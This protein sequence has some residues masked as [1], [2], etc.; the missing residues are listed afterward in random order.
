M[1]TS[2]PEFS[3][4]IEPFRKILEEA[5]VISGKRTK[6]SIKRIVLRRLSWNC[7]HDK[8]FREFHADPQNSV[9]IAYQ[10][11]E[12]E[13]CIYTDAS[14]EFWAA[15]V[16]Q[17]E[18]DQLDLKVDR[19]LHQPLAFLGGKLIG[20]QVNWT[21]FEKEA[22]AIYEVFEKLD[23]MLVVE[24]KFHI[25][26]GHRNLLFVFNPTAI[27]SKIVRYVICKVQRWAL[28]SSRSSSVIEHI[29]GD[30]NI[31]P[32]IM[33]RWLSGYRGKRMALPRITSKISE[34]D[35]LP[36][37]QCDEDEVLKE[38]ILS[39]ETHQNTTSNNINQSDT[40]WTSNGRIWIP[41]N[42]T[43]LHYSILIH[44]HCGQGGHQ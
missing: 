23:Y 24:H 15:V 7:E 11:A 31:M 43:E 44:N 8:N 12:L 3:T 38:I 13:L 9:E 22:F 16:T 37:V 2:I 14:D 40:P 18:E 10:N 25:F 30:K 4:H 1:K 39:Q 29:L 33:T 21:T 26:T 28:F 41:N 5:Y 20:H 19:Q 34:N 27:D 36:N 32:D 35:I 17:C 42:D 6:R